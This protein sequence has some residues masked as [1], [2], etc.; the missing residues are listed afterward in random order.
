M[1]VPIHAV[2][3]TTV[4]LIKRGEVVLTFSFISSYLLVVVLQISCLLYAA[5][6]L[7]PFLWRMRQD[8]DN[9]AVPALMAFA[10]LLGTCLLTSAYFFLLAINDP[11]VSPH[12]LTHL[13]NSTATI[14]SNVTTPF[15]FELFPADE[16]RIASN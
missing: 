7:V 13:N 10:D 11:Y 14:S 6:V 12:T 8:P 4:C 16:H 15:S 3:F 1:S 2:Y 9:T 5:H